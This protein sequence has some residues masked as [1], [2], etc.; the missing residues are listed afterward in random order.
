VLSLGS[1]DLPLTLALAATPPHVE[2]GASALD[3][4]A[5]RGWLA[6]PP[7]EVEGTLRSG[8]L[9][10]TFAPLRIAG[11]LAL[12]AAS[13]P[14]GGGVLAL[15]GNVQASGERLIAA[16]LAAERAGQTLAVTGEYDLGTGRLDA[17]LRATSVDLEKLLAGFV[18]APDVTG[19][20]SGQLE[21]S[22]PADLGA[23]R[24]SGE[25][26]IADGRIRGFSL[27]REFLGQY[28]ALGAAVAQLRGIDLERFDE[29]Q[30]TRLAGRF[31]LA[32][33]R[34]D[35]EFLDLEYRYTSAA[36][37]GTIGLPEGALVLGGELL[38]RKEVGAELAG[39]AR[40]EEEVIPLEGIGGTLA[41]PRLILN[42]A[43]MARLAA[44]YAIRGPLGDK[45]EKKLG[46]EGSEALKRVLDGIR[47][48]RERRGEPES[49]T[50]H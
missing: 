11:E 25:F 34:I 8:G 45:L 9:R 22:G 19:L 37:R 26:S 46:T 5:L 40:V 50:R 18:D 21:W 42:K 16:G 32:P 1:V 49:D 33:G 3:L 44:R 31:S 36:L 30:F 38:L 24:G 12:D 43:S 6:A 14:L 2:I 28:A 4:T 41:R 47:T 23:L 35:L 29:E 20:I 10:V 7:G 13:L 48:R 27:L 15:T 17:S 39:D